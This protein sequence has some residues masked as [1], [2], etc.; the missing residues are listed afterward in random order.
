MKLFEIKGKTALVTGANRGIGEAYVHALVKA[1]AVKVYTAVRDL[2]NLA[3]L[4][5]TYPDIVEP[6]LLDVTNEK[7]RRELSLKI[8]SLDILINNAGIANACDFSSD[9]ALEIARLEMET[10]Y[11]A[12]L[13]LTSTVLPALKKSKQAA[14]IN[15]CSIAALSSFPTI[16]PYSASKAA[17]HSLTQGCRAELTN[18]DIRVVG[19]YPGPIDTRMAAGMDMDKPHPSQ[20]AE[21]TFDALREGRG[22]VFPDAFSEQMYET[23]LKHPHE[24]EK[25]FAQMG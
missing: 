1:G 18:E 23:F 15:V 22:D 9:N 4:V 14:I 10:N 24:L 20:V 21:K 11:F 12:P 8:T 2:N 3:A 6:I 7:H 19:V 25:T 17:I 16:R 5:E 13:Q